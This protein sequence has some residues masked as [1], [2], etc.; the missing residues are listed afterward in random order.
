MIGRALIAALALTALSATAQAQTRREQDPASACVL[1]AYDRMI[2]VWTVTDSTGAA[3]IWRIRREDQDGL[4]VQIAGARTQSGFW[5]ITRRGVD[6]MR[7]EPLNAARFVLVTE[8]V[9]T[10]GCEEAR[11]GAPAAVETTIRLR[12]HRGRAQV[13]ERLEVHPDRF[14]IERVGRDDEIIAR[15]EGARVPN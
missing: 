13:R 6:D 10:L 12:E 8:G 7:H 5:L 14:L 2:G 1:A 15:Y 9:R 3:E 4:H 11:E